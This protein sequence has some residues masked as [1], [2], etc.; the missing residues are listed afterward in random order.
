MS[1]KESDTRLK[2]IL[3]PLSSRLNAF[4]EKLDEKIQRSTLAELNEVLD[5]YA[6]GDGVLVPKFFKPIKTKP[7]KVTKKYIR[8]S[9]SMIEDNYKFFSVRTFKGFKFVTIHDDYVSQFHEHDHLRYVAKRRFFQHIWFSI[10][11]DCDTNVY[12]ADYAGW[13][14][15]SCGGRESE[16]ISHLEAFLVPKIVYPFTPTYTNLRLALDALP[17][18]YDNIDFHNLYHHPDVFSN[19]HGWDVV[20]GEYLRRFLGLPVVLKVKSDSWLYVVQ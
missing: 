1:S 8:F 4:T 9:F 2:K 18:E 3:L 14:T 13:G 20:P 16:N 5:V 15:P 7:T 12:N 19:N 6:V 17:D 10:N 11:W